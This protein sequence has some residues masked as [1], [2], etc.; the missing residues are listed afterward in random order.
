[1]SFPLVKVEEFCRTGSGATPARNNPDYY[2][3]NIPWIK[4]GELRET[5]I[6]KS[7]EF[8][9]EHA[10]EKTAL[11][12]IPAGAI[13]V[14]MYGATVGRV[15]LLGIEATTN[16]AVCHIIPDPQVADARYLYHFMQSY[17]GEFTRRG[18]GGA[19]PNIS[20]GTI[21]ETPVPLPPL[22]EQQR[23]A[24]ILDQADALHRL[25]ARALDS[26]NSLGRAIFNEK[27]G[28]EARHSGKLKVTRLDDCA[29][30]FGGNTL[31]EG[32]PFCGQSDGFLILKVSDLNR[33]EN[34]EGVASAASWSAQSGS[35]A[36]TCPAG[37]IVFPKRGGAIATNKK[38][39][40]LRPAILDP[41]LMGVNPRT[42]IMEVGFL[43]AWFRTI[44]LASIS[45]G[46][47]VPQLNKKDLAPL[48]VLLP[49]IEMQRD[50]TRQW[51]RLSEIMKLHKRAVGHSEALFTSLQHRAFQGEL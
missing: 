13:L 12:L 22:E 44:D 15:G 50:F 1:M 4:S 41:N 19:Q 37:S 9:S 46:S 40:L 30:F 21:R 24:A 35:K 7:E 16:Q 38:R 32:V 29:E 39:R 31:P 11:K 20:Q 2:G 8:V 42:E 3:G 14:A 34:Y 43:E 6:F 49:E 5:L 33:P 25:R 17:A 10:L 36:S 18:V 27:F 28:D 23:I 26:L 51:A 45:S 48:E 47:S